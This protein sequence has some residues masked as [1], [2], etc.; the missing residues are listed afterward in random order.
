MAL[1]APAHYLKSHPVL[2]L[3]EGNNGYFVIPHPSKNY[4]YYVL[5]S[6]GE[7]WEHVS[8]SLSNKEIPS[9]DDMCFIKNLFWDAE[10][11][12]IQ[13]HPAKSEYVNTCSSYL[14]LWRPLGMTFPI[15]P[16]NLVG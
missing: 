1:K 3:G 16:K 10:D 7:S 12:V 9:W 11:W 4:V 15:P 2:G 13:F 5:C 14:H 6:D 8:I